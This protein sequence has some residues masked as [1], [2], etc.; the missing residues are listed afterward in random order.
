MSTSDRENFFVDSGQLDD[1]DEQ[2]DAIHRAAVSRFE[3]IRTGHHVW[4]SSMHD[5]DPDMYR[6][7]DEVRTSPSLVG[8]VRDAFPGSRIVPVPEADELYWA[9]SATTAKGSNRAL[10]DC[11]YDAPFGGML[12]NR[13]VFYRVIVA[14]NENDSTITVFP[15]ES[16][17]ARMTTGDF[18]GLDYNRDLHCV[19]G[20]IL[21]G[22]HRV[23]LKL[24]YMAVSDGA[25]AHASMVRW[26]NVTWTWASRELMRMS[27][28]PSTATEHAAAAL[29]VGSR[30][31][32]NNLVLVVI[33]MLIVAIA[34]VVILRRRR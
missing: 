21:Q 17:R 27:A 20:E 18:H 16:V 8:R 12:G 11:H 26:L 2:F 14:C 10:V 4:V 13:V 6:W 34:V 29:V 32:W 15:K 30:V 3:H 25:D 28:N 5:A 33:A 22:A 24:H 19:E 31:V 23:L 7:I 1:L 9:V